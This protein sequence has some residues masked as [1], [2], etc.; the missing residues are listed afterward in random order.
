MNDEWGRCFDPAWKISPEKFARRWCRVCL[1]GECQRSAHG[2]LRWVQRMA[3]QVDRLLIRP[4]I[5]DENDPRRWTVPEFTPIR[6]SITLSSEETWGPKPKA[7]EPVVPRSEPVQLEVLRTF[8]ARGSKGRTYTVSET[9]SGWVCSCPAFE[10]GR[11]GPCKHILEAMT[12]EPEEPEEAP[13]STEKPVPDPRVP[14]GF[15]N[16]SIP[17]IDLAP[18]YVRPSAPNTPAPPEGIMIGGHTP[19]PVDDPWAPKKQEQKI[20]VGGTVRMGKK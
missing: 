4:N 8:Q 6:E 7:A 20:S 1:N 2:K 16:T 3:T 9:T 19:T 18:R 15:K 17:Q 5:A 11:G 14:R 10:F 13:P 12:I